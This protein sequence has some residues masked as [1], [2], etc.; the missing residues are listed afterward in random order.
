[1]QSDLKSSPP[2][3]LPAAR[4]LLLEGWCHIPRGWRSQDAKTGSHSVPLIPKALGSAQVKDDKVGGSGPWVDPAGSISKWKKSNWQLNLKIQI[5]WRAG[6]LGCYFFVQRASS[7][8]LL[9]CIRIRCPVPAHCLLTADIPSPQRWRQGP[10]LAV[11]PGLTPQSW[12]RCGNLMAAAGTSI[13]C[14]KLPILQVRHLRQPGSCSV[15]VC[16]AVP[17]PPKLGCS[18]ER[19]RVQERWRV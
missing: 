18:W 8:S 19:R 11:L 16:P 4:P 7:S 15:P 3:L 2:R 13:T 1:M 10:V 5:K 9:R 12:C 6:H 14:T 17:T